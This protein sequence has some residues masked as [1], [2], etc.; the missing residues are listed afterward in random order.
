MSEGNDSRA[1]YV[2]KLAS[3]YVAPSSY[4]FSDKMMRS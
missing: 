3:Q 1:H 4:L 2:G